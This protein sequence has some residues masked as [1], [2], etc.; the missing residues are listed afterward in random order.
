MALSVRAARSTSL[1][2]LVAA[3]L[4]AW[5]LTYAWASGMPT[6]PGAMGAGLVEF[7]ALWAVMMTAMMLPSLAPVTDAYMRTLA[8]EPS[9]RVRA[10]RTAG[11]VLGYLLAWT[12]YGVAAYALARAAG[13][14]AED[15]A[16]AARWVA[17]GTLVVAGVYQL[18]P[19]KDVCLRHCRSPVGFLLHFSGLRGRFKDFRVGFLH[20]GV[21]VGCCW[22]LMLVLVAMGVMNLLWMVLVAGVVILEKTWR[23]GPRVALAV[24]VALI[25]LG[26]LVPAHPGLA[27]GLYQPMPMSM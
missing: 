20:G 7:L 27:P 12:A 3:A 24:G 15:H 13:V 14:L 8:R 26:L 4:V 17:A 22:G 23:H 2:A 16:D 10:M 5:T 6:G 9:P 18:T 21:C 25:A 19:L 1:G 11:L